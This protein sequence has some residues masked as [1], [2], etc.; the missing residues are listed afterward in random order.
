MHAEYM[1]V[2][3]AHVYGA[4]LCTVGGHMLESVQV[5]GVELQIMALI[6]I[7]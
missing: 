3:Y 2:T 6:A 1:V 4:L 5:S 7:A